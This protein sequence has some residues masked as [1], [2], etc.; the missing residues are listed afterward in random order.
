MTAAAFIAVATIAVA[1]VAVAARRSGSTNRMMGAAFI[2]AAAD[3][4][5]RPL[6]PC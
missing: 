2:A 6:P 4:D 3:P 5:C 1:T